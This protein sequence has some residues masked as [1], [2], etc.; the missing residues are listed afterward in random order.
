MSTEQWMDFVHT[1]GHDSIIKEKTPDTCNVDDIFSP[2]YA[3]L[4]KPETND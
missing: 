3:K 2:N 1:V 4:K